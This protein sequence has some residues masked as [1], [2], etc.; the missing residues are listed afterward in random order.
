MDQIRFDNRV[1][2]VTGAGAGLGREYA[3]EFARRGASVVVNDLGVARDGSGSTHSAADAVV[4]EIHQSGGKAAAN[5]DSVATPEGGKNIV[6]TALDSFGAVDVLVNNAG[7]LRDKSFA[8]MTIEE[9]D[10]VMNVH[11]RGAFCV[12]QPAL[13]VMRERGY[14]RIIVTSSTSGIFGNFGQ[15][16]YGAAK[17]GLVGFMNVLKLESEK[18]NVHMNAIAPNAY[19]RMT[20]NLIPAELAPKLQAKFNVPMV[21]YLCSE[22]CRENGSIFTMGAGW[23]AKTAVVCAPGVCLG[24]GSR[25]IRAE[26]VRENFAKITDLSGARPLNNNLE[27][28]Q[29]M[30]PLLK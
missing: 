9:W 2:I 11:L 26:E 13:S 27:T 24:D 16:N 3:L 12:T 17:M 30:E 14:G 25:E 7:F 23:Y 8:K 4:Q 20:E 19:S 15:S 18:Y 22:E 28:F 29:F 10:A 6:K 1:V 5:Y 21:V